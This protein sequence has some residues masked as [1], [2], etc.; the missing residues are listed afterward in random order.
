MNTLL[1]W[2]LRPPRQPSLTT[3]LL[4]GDASVDDRV[5]RL[6]LLELEAA[7]ERKLGSGGVATAGMGGRLLSG[8]LSSISSP[9]P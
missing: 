9:H 4:F 8:G 6:F 5:C 3:L 1:L 2:C 7:A